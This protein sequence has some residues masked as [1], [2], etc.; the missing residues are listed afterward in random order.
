MIRR[1]AATPSGRLKAT[2]T[3]CLGNAPSGDAGWECAGVDE[4][5]VIFISP[6]LPSLLP[7]ERP[8]GASV[9]F[10]E[11]CCNAAEIG[12]PAPSPSQVTPLVRNV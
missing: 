7:E 1:L 5:Q 11:R 3:R 6:S 2:R 9:V 12:T 8:E 4:Q 10:T